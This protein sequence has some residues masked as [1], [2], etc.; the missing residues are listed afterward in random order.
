M[1]ASTLNSNR[2]IMLIRSAGQVLV[3]LY[4]LLISI[5]LYTFLHEGGHALIG[6]LSGGKISGFS[7]NFWELSA[8]VDLDGAFS[9]AQ[10]IL[11]NIAGVSLPLLAWTTFVLLT[12]KQ[13]NPNLQLFK[14]TSGIIPI[15]S[16]L[17]WIAIP[18]L[19]MMGQFPGD[20]STNF[21]RNTKIFPPL[22]SGAALLLMVGEIALMLKRLGGG[23]GLVKRAREE[24]QDFWSPAS[25]WTL[26][27]L[28][29]VLAVVVLASIALNG[30]TLE[31]NQKALPSEYTPAGSI[32][33]RAGRIEY[34][35]V[36]QFR[37][38]QTA[39]MSFYFI[40]PELQSGPAEITLEGPGGYRNVFFKAG[41][42]FKGGGTVNPT[43]L[44]LE[45]GDY[46]IM[47]TFP[48][49]N[50]LVDIGFLKKSP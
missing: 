10:T 22:V 34:T 15:S 50:G 46:R 16:L 32:D 25:R 17:A 3:Y 12:P 38:E 43:D 27:A 9:P 47:M 4:L 40:L 11:I 7:V 45:P 19:V 39:R 1:T 5:V 30:G 36:H 33:L 29:A 24:M 18:I 8:H 13:V 37:L 35:A 20:D 44:A 2:S 23:R 42:R 48:K 49:M 6:A 26:L 28:T 14:F 21:V 41:D 31:K